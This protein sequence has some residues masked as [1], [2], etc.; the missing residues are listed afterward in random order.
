MRSMLF[1]FFLILLAACSNQ[2]RQVI[3]MQA[4]IDSLKQE[5]STTY[6]PGLGE[7]MSG[8]QFHHAKLWFA[9]KAENWEL[10]GFEMKEIQEALANIQHYNTDR[11]EIQEIGMINPALDSMSHAIQLQDLQ[12]F[13][14]SYSLLTATCNECHVATKHAFNLIK[15]P[16]GVPVPNQVFTLMNKK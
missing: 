5:L 10:A 9:G 14:N 1:L 15:I 4:S 12:E 16:E 11:P 3:S 13:R 2:K 8:I 7:F 6:T